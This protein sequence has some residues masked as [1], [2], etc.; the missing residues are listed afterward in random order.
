MKL[1]TAALNHNMER[2]ADKSIE[3]DTVV[4]DFKHPGA[5]NS[6]ELKDTSVAPND[7]CFLFRLSG[8]L[9]NHIYEL[10]FAAG[11][12][13]R[14]NHYMPTK[15]LPTTLSRENRM[16]L[17]SHPLKQV[18]R[19]IR[20]E[21]L[22]MQPKV[23]ANNLSL[24]HGIQ[25]AHLWVDSSI[26]A[27]YFANV[28]KLVIELPFKFMKNTLPGYGFVLFE[29]RTIFEMCSQHPHIKALVILSR[30][31]LHFDVRSMLQ[32]G[33]IIQQA[34]RTKAMIPGASSRFRKQVSQMSAALRPRK[35]YPEGS[36]KNLVVRYS[37]DFDE[38]LLREGWYPWCDKYDET[39][40]EMVRRWYEKGI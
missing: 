20:E 38:K 32:S 18:S 27:V 23:F 25:L 10:V 1:Q 34:I 19:Q 7:A 9:R 31:G 4:L 37:G 16:F 6:L 15:F 26:A 17:E 30:S 3:L 8:E 12:E 33:A 24:R 36:F 21:T 40:V 2:L 29:P 5:S 39:W 11:E 22:N 28:G 14:E 13:E 35:G